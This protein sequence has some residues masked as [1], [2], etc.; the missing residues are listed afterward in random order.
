MTDK[1]DANSKN[2]TLY[3]LKNRYY[4]KTKLDGSF[5]RFGGYDYGS[6]WTVS[7]ACLYISNFLSGATFNKII[8]VDVEEALKYCKEIGDKPSIV[9]F[10]SLLKEGYKYVSIDGN[11][12]ASY[13][14][15]FIDGKEDLVVQSD[16]YS[17]DP[18]RFNEMAVE[19]QHDVLYTERI[20]VVIL[21]RI[22]IDDMCHLFRSLN[23]QTKLN[24]QEWRQARVTPLAQSIRDYGRKTSSFFM[25]FNFKGKDP[26][27]KRTHEEILAQFAI[28]IEKDYKGF[29]KGTQLDDVYE[30]TNT[31][32]AK[33]ITALNKLTNHVVNLDDEFEGETL[34]KRLSRGQVHNLFDAFRVF[35][36]ESFKIDDYRQFFEWFLEVDADAINKSKSV[37]EENLENESYTYWTKYYGTPSCYSNI[38]ALFKCA[39]YQDIDEL[40]KNGVVSIIRK[41]SDSFTWT[42]KLELYEKQKGELRTGE[43]MNILDFYF[44]KYEADHV[45]SIKD[46]G[47]TDISNG[48][49]MT[50]IENRRKGANSN[51]AHFDFQK[52]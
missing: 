43:K 3:W 49:L 15:A 38:K 40:K 46:G 39:F 12:S 37:L 14:T 11:N 52:A 35:D 29:L 24:G 30:N 8:N 36:D 31:W 22:T 23:T 33:T 2:T 21:R 34:S 4:I 42:H 28:K 27:D 7:Q 26:I 48:E 10:Q 1:Y 20:E 44:G 45:K 6:G 32:S 16:D 25:N 19:L 9:Y 47:T 18:L 51:Q 5:Q 13:L 41:S 17:A 50:I